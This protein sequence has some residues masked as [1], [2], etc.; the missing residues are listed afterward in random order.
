LAEACSLLRPSASR[1]VQNLEQREVVRRR[2]CPADNRRS[3]V[4]ITDK[5]RGLINEI[6][7]ESEARYRYIESR[8]GTANLDELYRLLEHLV[9]A[10]DDVP[11]VFGSLEG[12]A[13]TS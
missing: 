5:G 4:S 7:P 2:A 1:I 10:L 13:E 12:E 8:F 6:A 9:D 11:P 3:L